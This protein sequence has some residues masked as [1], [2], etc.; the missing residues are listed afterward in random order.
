[1]GLGLFQQ[2]N[3]KKPK[4][5]VFLFVTIGN[6]HPT[7]NGNFLLGLLVQLLPELQRAVG[8]LSLYFSGIIAFCSVPYQSIPPW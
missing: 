4:N 7:Q 8:S 2:S 1:M 5:G 3:I 6:R